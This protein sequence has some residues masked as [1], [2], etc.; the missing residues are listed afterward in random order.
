MDKTCGGLPYF[1]PPHSFTQGQPCSSNTDCAAL[2]AC[3]PG[4]T[5]AC[6]ANISAVCSS[7]ADCD[8][9]ETG[10]LC[11]C[12]PGGLGYCGPYCSRS[13]G[14]STAILTLST[15]VVGVNCTFTAP[16][17][18][19]GEEPFWFAFTAPAIFT[20]RSPA[21]TELGSGDQAYLDEISENQVGASTVAIIGD[22]VDV[23]RAV[24]MMQYSTDPYYSRLYR[25]PL[26]ERDP[27]TFD[28]QADSVDT[29]VL[30]ANDLGNAGGEVYSPEQVVS[31]VQVRVS[32][33]NN[34][35]VANGPTSIV[36][37]EDIPFVFELGGTR[38][39]VTDPDSGDY[40]FD[41]R[42]FTVNMSCVNG[43]LFLN[44]DFLMS[45]DVSD[46]RIIYK[47]WPNEP[48]QEL[49][50]LH[51]VGG[52]VFGGGCQNKLQCSDGSHFT[53]SDTKY[54]FY[55]S[56][57]YGLV[58]SPPRFGEAPVGCGFCAENS[59]NKFLSIMGTFA[60]INTALAQ[61]TYLPDPNFNTRTGTNTEIIV[62]N[63]TDNG[64]IG[65]DITA[66]AY[67]DSLTI[68]TIV[69]SVNDRPIIGRQI[70]STR[71][72]TE[73][74][75]SGVT[76][77]TISDVEV[78]EINSTLFPLCSTLS[79]S[80]AEYWTRCGP[81]QRQYIDI[82]EDTLF[83]IT[84]DVM[85]I[86]DVDANEALNMASP[87][88]FCCA[89]NLVTGGAC[90]CG[91]PCLCLAAYCECDVPNVCYGSEQALSLPGQLLINLSVTSGMLSFYPPPGRTL[92][93]T[94][95]LEF[96]T[97]DSNG[98][99][100]PCPDQLG[101]MRNASWIALQT[102]LASFQQGIEQMFLSYQGRTHF[103][104][105]DVISIWV[106]DQGF[107]DSCYNDTL[108]ATDELHIR[109]VAVNNP[110]V[111][112]YPTSVM[113][114]QQGSA[115]YADYMQFPLQK[116]LAITC[117]NATQYTV[118]PH[119][120]S[121][122]LQFSDPDMFATPYGNLSLV[123]TIGLQAPQ[124]VYAGNFFLLTIL[125]GAD[126]WYEMFRNSI[127]L[128]TFFVQGTMPDLNELMH[129]LRYNAD[130]EY[131][132]YLPIQIMAND[133][134]NYGEC[135]GNHTC[136]K[137]DP[138]GNHS[139]AGS[140]R[141]VAQGIETVTLD[142]IIGSLQ[143][144]SLQVDCISCNQLSQCGWC[145][146]A[147]LDQGKCMIAGPGGGPMFEVCPVSIDG[148]SFRMCSPPTQDILV[149]IVGSVVA[150]VGFSILL[151][152]F[153]RW[154]Q[155]RHGNVL[156][157]ARK[158]QHSLFQ[159]GKKLNILPPEEANW[160]QF[161]VLITLA[162]MFIIAFKILGGNQYPECQFQDEYFLDQVSSVYMS[163]DTCIVRFVP[164]RYKSFPDNELPQVMIKFAYTH[165]P[166][167]TLDAQ[168]CGSNSSF[169]F[170]N[171][172]DDS[173]KYLGFYCNIE[174]LVPDHIV[175]P[176][177]VIVATGE[178]VTTVRAGPM[179]KDSPNF[180]MDFGPNSFVLQ[181]NNLV[182]RL[183]NISAKY[184]TFDVVHGQLIATDLVVTSVGTFTSQ[185]ADIIVATTLNTHV[186]FW[187]KEADFVCL[188]AGKGS[189]YV[190]N[191]C[192]GECKYLSE[193]RHISQ[194]RELRNFSQSIHALDSARRVSNTGSDV[195]AFV[196]S[197]LTDGSGF[198]N[199][200]R[201]NAEAERLANQCPIGA[202]FATRSEIPKIT[203]C[204]DLSVCSLN[205]DAQCLCK[206]NCD[207]ANLYP[208]GTCDDFGR[209][210][211]TI[212]AGYSKADLFPDPNQ[213]RCGSRIDPVSMPWCNGQGMTQNFILTSTTGQISLQVLNSGANE[214]DSS[215]NATNVANLTDSVDMVESDKQILDQL[216]HPYGKTNPNTDSFVFDL[217][218]PGTVEKSVGQ[219]VW[220][221]S[222]HY[223]T[224]EPW[225][226]DVFSLG[227]LSFQEGTSRSELKPSFCPAI[228]DDSSE[229]FN[230]RLI[231]VRQL[232]LNVLQ[233][234][235]AGSNQPIPASSIL[236][237]RPV[238]GL[239]RIFYI[240]PQTNQY[241]VNFVE[242][243]DDSAA[244]FF[245]HLALGV[246][247]GLCLLATS[248]LFVI[249]DSRM[250][251]YREKEIEREEGL[252]NMSSAFTGTSEV[253]SISESARREL[254]GRT[255]IHA[256]IEKF[257]VQSNLQ[258]QH[259]IW[260]DFSIVVIQTILTM[261]PAAIIYVG[262]NRIQS[263]YLLQ[264]CQFRP[265]YCSCLTENSQILDAASAV[266]V[267]LY[268]YFF[269]A[270]CEMS[271]SSLNFKYAEG[272]FLLRSLFYFVSFWIVAGSIY[273]ACGVI[274]FIFLGLI[275]KPLSSIPYSLGIVCVV[276]FFFA[277]LNRNT[278]FRKRTDRE[279]RKRFDISSKYFIDELLKSN[280]SIDTRVLN[281]LMEFNIQ[282][283][284]FSNGVSESR[285]MISALLLAFVLIL[286][287]GFVFVAFRTF[288][289]QDQNV[290]TTAINACIVVAMFGFAFYLAT[291][292]QD[293]ADL[294]EQKARRIEKALSEIMKFTSNQIKMATLMM[295]QVDLELRGYSTA[296]ESYSADDDDDGSEQL[297]LPLTVHTGH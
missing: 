229:A 87:R 127:G 89:Q 171:S 168:N 33:V 65:N 207:M 136:G 82:D 112:S 81:L 138:C 24:Q 166:L 202:Q 276:S 172:R 36:A 7:N 264:N 23:G 62:F 35:P 237:Y 131:T 107:T 221:R 193:R 114:Y 246:P 262:T 167:I 169:I 50:G 37:T 271:V 116:G 249:S 14:C 268:L 226:F 88:R 176:E 93:A 141:P 69:E 153:L 173:T 20:C 12:T 177:V 247:A 164:T 291:R 248:V 115:C 227:L 145:P 260:L 297:D 265:D 73:Y 273:F 125:K 155:K 196:C 185:D 183:Q 143:V 206:P 27:L 113:Q 13:T 267:I 151:F 124:H 199:C 191:N 129:S 159:S 34:P 147:C 236:A 290:V 135:D 4:V 60:D 144:C 208:P 150:F 228:V 197:Q 94:E 54:G 8:H 174:V 222:V 220:V 223:L 103:F 251:R 294:I 28:I 195:V 126:V 156:R 92:F 55:A 71:T 282:Q 130:P 18:L 22:I 250:R 108:V 140:H 6:C 200:S 253:V 180:G 263:K 85:W 3:T 179:D 258:M 149:L 212:C 190:D 288:T 99:I 219:L 293:E 56:L 1:P 244:T 259:P 17:P 242:Q 31:S 187:Q 240:D 76:S 10:S 275:I 21:Y 43:R 287:Y 210:C 25:P 255:G 86:N 181:G 152:I 5:C 194:Q 157:Y 117:E 165:D 11:G 49:R 96:L 30:I 146:G 285:S 270:L 95:E 286:S 278:M 48:R 72:Q 209:C 281:S 40:G 84:P 279:I 64:A 189:L 128:R 121:A 39:Y 175:M 205:Q 133:N 284:L 105:K 122:G 59:G 104:G 90:Y 269:I 243:A 216:F 52:P 198:L 110:P 272:R 188:T 139:L 137:L 83:I 74:P 46:N 111:I 211:Q 215:F 252:M 234:Y 132:G 32:A 26:S 261:F 277:V 109:V 217:Q 154:V 57:L 9:F 161:L 201:Y 266:D 19:P 134:Y 51:S 75:Q 98:K 238:N 101:C 204:Y 170:R 63:V 162:V 61:V 91:Q 16:W 184:F 192:E 118:P 70:T 182:V 142:V 283:V 79:P 66:P 120:A 58:Y 123:M 239:P 203:G 214:S 80:G 38:L 148:S 41:V 68:K 280:S 218:G 230:Q 45:E 254:R 53:S 163:L 42:L 225:L 289:V 231:T 106:S 97:V 256:F 178:N 232:L 102:D 47:L 186:Q 295:N 158:K 233:S 235:P 296:E 100:L 29:L 213:P 292:H 77:K 67:Y 160:V 119:A 78:V 274:I 15:A 224:M 257:L 245:I 2:T 44:E 241:A